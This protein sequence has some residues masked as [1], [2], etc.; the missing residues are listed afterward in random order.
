MNEIEFL[1]REAADARAALQRTFVD[2][3][4]SVQN[5]AE[6]E[7]W[8]AQHPWLALAVAASVGFGAGSALRPGYSEGERQHLAAVAESEPLPEPAFA[9]GS[10]AGALLSIVGRGV[11]PVAQALAGFLSAPPP[12][13]PKPL[14]DPDG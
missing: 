9:R 3:Q 6:V 10:L 1:R 11:S 8:M 14:L 4:Q 12:P 13:G 7:E 2:L 5:A